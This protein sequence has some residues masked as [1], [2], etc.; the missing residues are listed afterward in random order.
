MDIE[1]DAL[2]NIKEV[3]KTTPRGMNVMEIANAISMNRQSVAKYMEMLVIS[4]FVDVKNFGSSKVY[5]LS[6]RL[7]ISAIL[8]LSSDFIIILDKDLKIVHAND[9]FLDFYKIKREDLIY[10]NAENLSFPLEFDPPIGMNIKDALGGRE[11][12]INAVY[13]KKKE[14]HFFII[15]FIPLVFEDGKKGVTIIFIDNTEQRKIELAINAS[16]HKLRSIIDQSVDGILLTDEQGTVIEYNTG[17][18]TITGIKKEDA[19]GKKVWDIIAETIPSEKRY[20]ESLKQFKPMAKK[21]LDVGSGPYDSKYIETPIGCTDGKIKTVQLVVFSIKTDNGFMLCQI[22]RDITD[23]KQ[24]EDMLR[25]SENKYRVL[26]EGTAAALVVI[27]NDKFIEINNATEMMTGYSKDELLKMDFWSIIHPDYRE[28]VKGKYLAR[29]RG[30]PVSPYELMFITKSGEERWAEASGGRTTYKGDTVNVLTYYDIT[31]RKKS[32]EDLT[33]SET[34]LAMS[35]EIAHLGSWDVDINGHVSVSSD[36]CYR[37]FGLDP[38]GPRKSFEEFMA[39]LHPDDRE[40]IQNYV[41]SAISTGKMFNTRFRI[42]LSDGSIRHI[43]CVLKPALDNTG[44]PVTMVGTVQ[45]ITEQW[46]MEEE[47]K[48]SN[49]MIYRAQSIAHLGCFSYDMI[50]NK[51]KLSEEDYKIFGYEQDRSK[52]DYTEVLNIVHPDD[53]GRMVNS[54]HDSLNNSRPFRIEYRIIRGDGSE[55]LIYTEGEFSFDGT[56]KPYMMVGVN[57]DVTDEKRSRN[58]MSYLATFPVLNPNPIIEISEAGTVNFANPAANAIFQDLTAL[59]IKHPLFDGLHDILDGMQTTTTSKPI[60]RD[61]KVSDRYYQVII[62][63]VPNRKLTRVYL[64]DVTERKQAETALL[65]GEAT[66]NLARQHM[67]MGMWSMDLERGIFQFTDE[68]YTVLGLAPQSFKPT[69]ENLLQ[70]VVPEDKERVKKALGDLLTN[71]KHYK[72][73]FS[74]IRR[75]GVRL[76][77][78]AEGERVM[79]NGRPIKI[80]G[81]CFD[82]TKHDQASKE[83]S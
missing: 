26:A 3:L 51:L 43:H 66:L 21:F 44:A 10:Q 29:L 70:A 83:L 47:L 25:D 39:F 4:G 49:A 68:V 11:S 74:L 80:I 52:L 32:L 18:E 63:N 9:K 34:N 40:T 82:R 41:D 2:A 19:L 55:R 7:P 54:I 36:E 37:I 57:K 50:T 1:R 15:K 12:S 60:L 8:S 27:N 33:R 28:F 58:R 23:R 65:E 38:K 48:K 17:E 72:L 79:D 45:D 16:E 71:G 14:E 61:I 56:G 78:M 20:K 64:I 81:V 69:Y 35:Q 30:E 22:A 42:I 76:S 13:K 73:E 62:H 24:I 6:Q 77:I 46:V 67:N 53:R 5:Y 59:G 31:D 75:D